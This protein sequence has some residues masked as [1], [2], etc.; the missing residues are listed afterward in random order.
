MVARRA[1]L[2]PIR[3][4]LA[5]VIGVSTLLLALSLLGLLIGYVETGDLTWLAGSVILIAGAT[6][7]P[8][9]LRPHV[10]LSLRIAPQLMAA[11]LLGP[12]KAM[13]AAGV[14]VTLGY[15]YHVLY[16]R[17]HNLIDLLF[18]TAQA[19][20]ATGAASIIY[21]LVGTVDLGLLGEP[22]ALLVAAE[23][24]H[25]G[26]VFLVAG[27]MS[28]SGQDAGLGQTVLHLLRADPLQYVALLVTGILGALLARDAYFWA[29]PLLVVPLALVER[30]LVRQ[31]EEAERERRLAVME[32]VNQLKNDFIAAVT[33]D[34][35]T[36]LMV[37]KG[38]GELLAE[39]EDEFMDDER[40]AV[41]CI[42]MN[43]ERL[44]E[45]IE[46]L[47]QMS[48]LDA[49]MVVLRRE[50]TDAVA[51]IG[52]VIE[53]VRLHAE[54]K[55]VAVAMFS[56]GRVPSL[57]LDAAR[58]EQVI[59]NVL[60]NAI[61]FTPAEGEVAVIVGFRD[62][63]LAV[64][65]SDSGPGIPA[66]VLPYVFDRFYRAHHVDGD[67]KSTGGLGLAIAKSIVELHGGTL[68]VESVVGEGS[69]FT[70]R[71]PRR[72]LSQD[73]RDGANS[74]DRALADTLSPARPLP[75]AR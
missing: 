71:I 29:V 19:I 46:M 38:F 36:P 51:L 52:R 55:G 58:F 50:P 33:H 43:T 17:R 24:M 54:Q 63:T 72:A 2:T 3:L 16:A 5:A 23:G 44:S 18:N 61:K 66:D 65:V 41:E 47:L 15:L 13:L 45:L 12:E 14:G 39:R 11:V 57:E 37:I 42:N 67:R 62:E 60:N 34:L 49:G 28:Y 21:R 48:E 53:R 32:E 10:R 30:T 7:R 59:A 31:R 25:L 1:A 4:Y 40:R 9:E 75:S 74:G 6:A 35:R 64:T 69:S 20:L 8:V 26:N 68:R 27:A 73:E 56:A 70:V 22:V